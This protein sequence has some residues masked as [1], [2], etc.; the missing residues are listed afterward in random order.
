MSKE[1]S[2]LD[3]NRRLPI[4]AGQ[5][6]KKKAIGPTVNVWSV[7]S[8]KTHGRKACTQT[9]MS[10]DSATRPVHITGTDDNHSLDLQACSIQKALKSHGVLCS[11]PHCDAR[12]VVHKPNARLQQRRVLVL[13]ECRQPLS[14]PVRI[15]EKA[16]LVVGARVPGRWPV[17]LETHGCPHCG[18]P[19]LQGCFGPCRGS[20]GGHTAEQS[21]GWT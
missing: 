18:Y 17:C 15:H 9:P 8:N 7:Q 1:A 6:H 20:D 4:N 12:K 14:H 19:L 5:A 21:H 13:H 10:S 3:R 11:T 2:S 16:M